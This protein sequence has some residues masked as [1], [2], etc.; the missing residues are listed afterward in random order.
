LIGFQKR[1]RV[2]LEGEEY[3]AL[4]LAVLERDHWQ[5]RRCGH[6][7]HLEVHHIVERSDLRLD[8]M[9]NLCTLCRRCHDMFKKHTLFIFVEQGAM[10]NANGLLRFREK[11]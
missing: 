3:D 5:C 1:G 8:T 2:L 10:P 4:R 7:R 11:E 6:R 9:E